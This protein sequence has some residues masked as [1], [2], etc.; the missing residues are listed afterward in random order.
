MI[1]IHDSQRSFSKPV[2]T[3]LLI[4]LNVLAFLFELWLDPF[5]RND[6]IFVYGFVPDQVR[7]LSPFTSMFLHGGWLHLLGNMLFLWVFGDNIEDLLGHWQFLLFYLLGGLCAAAGQYALDPYSRV[8]MIGASGAIAAVMGAYVLKFPHSRIT[9][10]GWF[11]ILFTFDLPA[12]I[13]LLYWFALQFLSGVGS[14]AESYS[15]RGG[16]AFFAHIGGFLS[17]MGLIFLFKTRDRYR[18]RRDLLW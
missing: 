2:V 5:T 9:M 3:V 14:V 1:P 12:Y 17:G 4:G 8:P 18:L 15:Q 13:V 6:F 7:L 16:T 11:V 10:V